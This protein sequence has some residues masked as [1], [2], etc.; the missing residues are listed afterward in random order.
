MIGSGDRVPFK[1]NACDC[2]AAAA[3]HRV[4]LGA[5][6]Y[7]IASRHVE[8]GTALPRTSVCSGRPPAKHI[9]AM[10]RTPAHPP[11][12]N[13]TNTHQKETIGSPLTS[14]SNQYRLAYSDGPRRDLEQRLALGALQACLVAVITRASSFVDACAPVCYRVDSACKSRSGTP[15]GWVWRHAEGP[16]SK[17]G[18]WKSL[19]S[20]SDDSD[21]S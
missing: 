14:S 8:R 18:R 5:T 3:S 10:T 16:L 7:G 2:G 15:L 11:P 1:R 12:I 20:A 19:A 21:S 4:I 13:A 17:V 9:N 6:M